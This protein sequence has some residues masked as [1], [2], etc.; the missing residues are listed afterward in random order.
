M[1][2]RTHVFTNLTLDDIKEYTYTHDDGNTRFDFDKF[3]PMPDDIPEDKIAGW[4]LANWGVFSRA[5]DVFVNSKGQLVI[6]TIEST[7]YEIFDKIVKDKASDRFVKI[8]IY[9]EDYSLAFGN[10]PFLVVRYEYGKKI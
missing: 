8:E 3:E 1:N 6:D 9:D 5:S 4:C 2:H 10:E 7:P